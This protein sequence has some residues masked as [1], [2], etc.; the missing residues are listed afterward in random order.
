MVGGE[1]RATIAGGADSVDTAYGWRDTGGL[2]GRVYTRHLVSLPTSQNPA[3]HLVIH[4]LLDAGNRI[5]Y[6]LSINPSRQLGL[7]SPPGGLRSSAIS[8]PLTATVPTDGTPTRIEVSA[9]ANTS[10]TVRANGTDIYTLT[11]LTGATTTAPRHLRTGSIRYDSTTTQPVT[12]HHSAVDITT[13]GWL[14]TP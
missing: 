8:I 10:I 1:L 12:T 6:Q 4:Q 9:L 11:G 3:G 7:Y 2:T 5:V 14:G 13:T